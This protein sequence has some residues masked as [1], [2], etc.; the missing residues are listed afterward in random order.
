[1]TNE[2]QT[3]GKGESEVEERYRH[4]RDGVGP[5]FSFAFGCI[6]RAPYVDVRNV[7]LNMKRPDRFVIMGE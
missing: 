3:E 1:M 4:V 2:V 6:D 7:R 5:S